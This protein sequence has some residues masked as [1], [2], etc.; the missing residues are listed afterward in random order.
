MLGCVDCFTWNSKERNFKE[1]RKQETGERGGGADTTSIVQ[2]HVYH[3]N[4]SLWNRGDSTST[5][6][7]TTIT[8]TTTRT[9]RTTTTPNS[10]GAK[11]TTR[12]TG[13]TRA[14]SAKEAEPAKTSQT[15][16]TTVR[17]A[18]KTRIVMETTK[19]TQ[20]SIPAPYTRPT[21]QPPR[22]TRKIT[23]ENSGSGRGYSRRSSVDGR[24]RGTTS[25]T[26]PSKMILLKQSE[27]SE[28]PNN[29]NIET[30]KVSNPTTRDS[31]MRLYSNVN[32]VNNTNR[33]NNIMLLN[34]R[35]ILR[36]LRR[37]TYLI[38]RRNTTRTIAMNRVM[39]TINMLIQLRRRRSRRTIILTKA[40]STPD[41]S[42]HRNM[43]LNNNTTNMIR[44]RRTS[45]YTVTTK[46]RLY[47]RNL[48]LQNNTITRRANIIRR[49]LVFQRTKR[50]STKNQDHQYRHHSTSNRSGGRY[51]GTTKGYFRHL[52]TGDSASYV[53]GD[54]PDALT[55]GPPA[56]F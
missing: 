47:I 41:V 24:K 17:A 48:S 33:G 18:T 11:T 51:H 34:N 25:G 56:S 15:T 28:K 12:A 37:K 1:V 4:N 10:T 45:L 53:P 27:L 50:L 54:L 36:N 55:K 7:S 26:F 42:N 43:I 19:E 13:T 23:R 30:I 29:L 2:S 16:E 49:T 32:R 8:T 35:V 9:T 20:T 22:P 44:D 52:R 46:E 14:A 6:N 39:I 21:G 3:T 38:N 5:S 40:T 31:P